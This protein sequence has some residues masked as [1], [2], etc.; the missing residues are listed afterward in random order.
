MQYI[1]V[2][3]KWSWLDWHQMIVA[4]DLL[5]T[6]ITVKTK[7]LVHWYAAINLVHYMDSSSFVFKKYIYI[8]LW[9]EVALFSKFYSNMSWI[10]M[11]TIV[12]KDSERWYT[13]PATIS[14][15]TFVWKK[16]LFW[17][18]LFSRYILLKFQTPRHNTLLPY[19]SWSRR[20]RGSFTVG[21]TCHLFS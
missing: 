8:L 21:L 17:I 19:I 12:M 10:E 11:I 1:T 9:N 16:D 3:G 2:E 4:F 15:N 20:H 14:L 6:Y 5:L 7:G 18:L 13:L